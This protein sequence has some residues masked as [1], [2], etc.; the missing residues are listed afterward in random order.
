MKNMCGNC[1]AER[2]FSITLE[3]LAVKEMGRSFE[4]VNKKRQA[5]RHLLIVAVIYEGGGW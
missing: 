2:E 1:L 5:V 3:T 4:N